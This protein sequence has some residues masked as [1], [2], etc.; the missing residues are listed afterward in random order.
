MLSEIEETFGVEIEVE[1]FLKQPYFTYLNTCVSEKKDTVR[2]DA[3]DKK[4]RELPDTIPATELQKA[5]L[6]GR[7]EG[8]ATKV[9]Y[10]L[11]TSWEIDRLEKAVNC[12]IRSQPALRLRISR[13]G[14]M[15][16]DKTGDWYCIK[17]MDLS[18]M[19]EEEKANALDQEFE[20]QKRKVFDT[21]KEPLF[22]IQA[23]KMRAGDTRLLIQM[24]MLIADGMS[25]KLFV[26]GIADYY[27]H[28]N[29]SDQE[30]PRFFLYCLEKQEE[31]HSRQYNK[32]RMYWLDRLEQ[33]PSAPP[34][35][36]NHI[37][38]ENT[39]GFGR[40]TVTIDKPSWDKIK[41]ELKK[42]SVTPSVL[43]MSLYAK[44][45]GL[46]S[47]SSR[48]TLNVPVFN[49]KS[50]RGMID[51][52]GDFTSVLLLDIDL[53]RENLL[54]LCTSV[55]KK[56]M[57]EALMHKS[58][59]GIEFMREIAK[60]RGTKEASFPVVFTSLLSD[61]FELN[62]D[63]IGRMV[64]GYSQTS[65]VELDCQAYEEKG[66]L[67]IN[68]D[69]KKGV[70][71]GN[72]LERMFSLFYYDLAGLCTDTGFSSGIS[73][74]GFLKRLLH[75]DIE[76]IHA[77]NTTE[78]DIPYVSLNQLLIQA[79]GK[80]KDKAILSCGEK[81]MSYERLWEKSGRVK[82][83]L[84]MKGVK[85]GSNV[86]VIGTRDF[87]TVINILGVIR[88]GAAYIPI[89]EIQ[90][91]E[92]RKLILEKSSSSVILERNM[93]YTHFEDD[94]EQEEPVSSPDD[95]A[96][97]IFTSGS[98]GQPKGVYVKH[99]AVV[100]TILDI[101]RK[102]QVSDQDVIAC[103]SS[104]GFDLSVY[105]IFGALISGAELALIPD[106]HDTEQMMTIL[107]ERGV[108]VWNSVPALF[109]MLTDCLKNDRSESEEYFDDYLE[110]GDTF[111]RL[112]SLKL[113]M[114][115]G[116]W[117]PKNLIQEAYGYFENCR[118]ISLGGATEAS[119][120]S[121]YYD[122]K[123]VKNQ[124]T[125]IPYGYPLANQNIYLL[126]EVDDFVPVGVK[127]Q[128][129]IG[130][131]GVAEGYYQ[132]QEKTDAAFCKKEGL[133]RI[134]HTGDYGVFSEE[135]CILFLG[136]KDGQIKINGFRIELGEIENAIKGLPYVSNA[137]ALV[138]EYKSGV[139]SVCAYV[140]TSETISE[141]KVRDDL[142][143]ILPYY[144]IPSTVVFLE[145]I[146]LTGNGKLDRKSL[147]V[148][149]EPGELMDREPQTQT[150]KDLYEIWKKYLKTDHLSVSRPFM[151]LGGDS[152]TMISVVHEIKSKFGL[153]VP[154]REFMMGGSIESIAE[155]IE[156]SRK[157]GAAGLREYTAVTGKQRKN[158][159]AFR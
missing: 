111:R 24:D 72:I 62:L 150:Q 119:V 130:G 133:G 144:M 149:K 75:Q 159:T 137:A 101:N 31:K 69:Y 108:T 140:C 74:R 94:G 79:Y 109:Q 86:A 84:K 113:V 134:Y 32:D 40:K 46:Y 116:D 37:P 41:E 22:T 87:D 44:I 51:A 28:E 120:W 16:A 39:Q 91:E 29:Q 141:R 156:S 155:F 27:Q 20:L 35:A 63:K 122:I 102:F 2:N 152:L 105:D 68:W 5:Y 128:I 7:E 6:I 124:W 153:E 138:H 145:R 30:D 132:D 97:I 49:R 65:Q 95:I 123:E 88:S 80:Y 121:I 148:I 18:H 17:T 12:M 96:Y 147:P 114:L 83:Y 99:G 135:G 78:E 45:L 61:A 33:F 14:V 106:V 73:D 4:I 103:V 142:S 107:S 55:Q 93:D 70:F 92:R 90:P 59:D 110:S 117:I 104:I 125:S 157:K 25:L 126:D 54:D 15:H 146:P 115:S 64:R 158:M 129:C 71:E 56:N 58:F 143:S 98:T 112:L 85:A 47:G 11:S 76:M 136:R 60:V 23:I 77:Y 10:E 118:M 67:V 100:N 154:F 66:S 48:F 127:G 21:E 34:L 52:I 42:Y 38:Q 3:A 50:T 9:L 13:E 8:I 131:I 81:T 139:K 89:D 1:D 57:L 26:D 151:E 19:T 43:I 53:S 82:N 36:V